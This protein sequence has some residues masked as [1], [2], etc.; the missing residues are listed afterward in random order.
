MQ[1]IIRHG[2]DDHMRR[3]RHVKRSAQS[4]RPPRHGQTVYQGDVTDDLR[5]EQPHQVAIAHRGQGVILHR[6]FRQRL[7]PDKQIAHK[8][9]P[10]VFG[11]RGAIDCL[12]CPQTRHDRLGHG[13]DIA[14]RRGIECAAILPVKPLNA[15]RLQPV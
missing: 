3:I 13:A 6:A 1:I 12:F 9:G 15:P 14:L 7:L 10:P 2:V 11:K 8:H 4:L 5:R